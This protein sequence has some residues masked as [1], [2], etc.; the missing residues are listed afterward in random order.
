MG[1][2]ANHAIVF[3]QLIVDENN[4]GLAPFLVQLRDLNTHKHMKGIKTGDLGP[5]MGYVSKD[6]GWL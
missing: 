2:T 6:N 4:Y 3:A 1:R 5:K